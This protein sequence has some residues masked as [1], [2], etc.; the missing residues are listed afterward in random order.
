MA[1]IQ[2]PMTERILQ[3]NIIVNSIIGKGGIQHMKISIGGDHCGFDLKTIVIERLLSQGHEVIDH[4]AYDKNPVDF[5]DMA[6]KICGSILN[7]DADR[8]IMLCGSGIGAAIAC[9]KI[10]GI[11][12]SVVHDYYSA[13][14][15]VEH[16]DVQ[17]MCMGE[18]IVGSLLAF[19]LIDTFL[20]AEFSTDPIYRIK[21]A[22]L[23][24]MDGTLKANS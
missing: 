20:K 24:R 8:A 6:H 10:P 16:D 2:I 3:F 4:G 15:A 14:Q 11:R 13:H 23:D 19:D 21:V 22:K 7:G 5:P 18:W 1:V 17:V 12:A 9:N